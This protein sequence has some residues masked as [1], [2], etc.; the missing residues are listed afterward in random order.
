MDSK[1]IKAILEKYW[2]GETSLEEEARLRVYF[3]QDQIAEELV[4]FQPMFQ[5]F[6]KEQEAYLNGDF[7]ERLSTKLKAT[8][9]QQARSHSLTVYIKRIAAVAA[10][11]AGLIFFLSKSDFIN[12]GER[13]ALDQQEETEAKLAYAEAKAALL[14]ISTKLKKGT[15]KAEG[16]IVQVRKATKVIRE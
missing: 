13:V 12:P 10:V 14:L 1:T 11:A 2:E 9:N 3:N 4:P 16:G 8:D 7:D 5:F 6:A 15:D